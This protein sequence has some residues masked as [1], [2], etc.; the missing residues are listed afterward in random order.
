MENNLTTLNYNNQE[1]SFEA[2]INGL[3]NLTQMAK[4][5]GVTLSDYT[6][7]DKTKSYIKTL[8]LN[9][10]TSA[11]VKTE[12]GRNGGTW[13]HKLLAIHFAQWISDEFYIWCNQ[14]ILGILEPESKPKYIEVN[15]NASYVKDRIEIAKIFGFEGNQAILSA[16]KMFKKELGRDLLDEFGVELISPVKDKL[17]TPTELGKESNISAIK[18]N[19]MLQAAGFQANSKGQWMPTEKGKPYCEVLDTGKKRSN[20]TP[21]KQLKWYSKVMDVLI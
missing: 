11:V 10:G 3:V 6:R 19:E 8:E 15:L 4:A 2:D 7:L 12:E 18:M 20:G 5:T 1:I 13:G 9:Y 14:N 21:I 16:N 17:F